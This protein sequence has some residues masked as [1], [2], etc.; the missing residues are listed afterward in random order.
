MFCENCNKEHTG[1]YGSGR[2]CGVKCSR[3]FSTKGKRAEINVRV[4]NTLA[5][6]KLTEDHIKN[7]EQANNFNRKE[8]T[9]RL[10]LECSAEM[11]CRPSDTR[12]FCKPGCWANY[13]EKNKEPFL[14]YRQRANFTFNLTDFPDKFNLSL[15][16]QHGLYSPANKGN[17]LNGISR[18]HMLSVKDG[19]DLGIDPAI[20]AHPANC[21]IMLHTENQRKNSKSTITVEELLQRIK[22]W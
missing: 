4:S 18:D 7:I 9:T 3:G 11:Q 8:K 19:F 2:F 5:G 17:N 13:T 16:E 20:L 12:K 21:R 6:R 22:Q 14:L 10:C 1:L 15:I